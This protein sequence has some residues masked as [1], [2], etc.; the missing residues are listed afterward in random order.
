MKNVNGRTRLLG[1]IGNPIEHTLSPFIHNYLSEKL[2]INEVY[3]PFLVEQERLKEAVRGAY[4]LNVFGMNVTIPYK[5]QVIEYLKE[6]DVLAKEIGAV[7][8]L[9]RIK[10]GYKGYNTD[11]L[12]LYKTCL[13]ALFLRLKE[14]RHRTYCIGGHFNEQRS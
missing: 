12:G 2:S 13:G 6:I 7:N 5:N 1:L 4:A 8:T 14:K 9:V 11:A 10:D 3:V